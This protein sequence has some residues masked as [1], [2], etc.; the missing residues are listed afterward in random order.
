MIEKAFFIFHENNSFQIFSRIFQAG[1]FHQKKN[2]L[3][4]RKKYN[5][6]ISQTLSLWKREAGHR[7]IN[8]KKRDKN[9]T[10]SCNILPAFLSHT[11]FK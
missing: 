10:D 11:V 6:T 1:S 3:N 2:E 9:K 8:Q 4:N 5:L 7:G